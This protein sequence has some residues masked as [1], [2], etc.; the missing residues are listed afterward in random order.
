VNDVQ[1]TGFYSLVWDG[2]DEAGVQLSSGTYLYRIDARG[3]AGKSFVST[4]KMVLIK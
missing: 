2:R 3:D 4:K 1:P